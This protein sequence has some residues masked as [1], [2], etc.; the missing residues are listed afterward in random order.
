MLV[1]RKR[2]VTHKEGEKL[3]GEQGEKG[4]YLLM[5]Y[6]QFEE[7]VLVRHK[8]KKYFQKCIMVGFTFEKK[9]FLCC[10]PA[11]FEKSKQ[12]QSFTC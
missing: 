7:A 2:H 9:C 11:Y 4:L 10:T 8:G 6:S 1:A 5:Y 3:L 12:M